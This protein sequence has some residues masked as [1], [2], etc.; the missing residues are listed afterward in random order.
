MPTAFVSHPA[1][2]A[3][4]TGTSH[5]DRPERLSA[6]YDQL[7]RE[8]LLPFLHE[9]E[10]RSATR[11]ELERVHSP[12]YVDSLL[13]QIPDAGVRAL[14]SDTIMDAATPEA[15]FHAAGAVA[16]ATELVLAKKVRNA[17]CCVRPPGHHATRDAAM[18]FCLINNVAVGAAHALARGGLERVAIID[19][20][21][22]HGNGTESIFQGD[23]RVLLCSAYERGLF[24]ACQEIAS[25]PA[26]RLVPIVLERGAGGDVLRPAILKYWEPAIAAFRPE[27]IFVSAGFDGHVADPMSDLSLR[28]D[29]FQWLSE[30]VMRMARLHASDR[31]ISVLEGGYDLPSLGRCAALH[32]RALMRL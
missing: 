32:I 1:C 23:A 19:F 15:A 24:P 11:E 3:H 8:H 26:D 22:H 7:G 16:L 9:F 27:M 14:D 18:G 12:Q 2:A 31:L 10:A 21:A 30:W 17:F 6:I 4:L 20:D 29:D 28:D 25:P 5:P 13:A